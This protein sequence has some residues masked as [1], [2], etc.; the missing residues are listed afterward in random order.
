MK[1][2][3]KNGLARI[4]V[5]NRAINLEIESTSDLKQ[6]GID[7]RWSAPLE[8][9]TTGR[10]DCEDYAIAKYMALK[11]AGFAD[12]DV[13]VVVVRNTVAEENHAVTAVRYE[14]TWIILDNRWLALVQDREMWRAIPLFILDQAGVRAFVIPDAAPTA[15]LL[16]SS[17][18]SF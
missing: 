13:K 18:S 16:G 10:G 8:T 15:A 14:G 11:L 4:G 1:G 7:D 12:A 17:P 5:I 6:W 9:F 2:A 3:R